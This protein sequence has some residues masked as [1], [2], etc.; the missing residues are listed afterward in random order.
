M[1]RR[2]KK[3]ALHPSVTKGKRGK[4]ALE[5]RLLGVEEKMAAP[6]AGT[7]ESV[8]TISDDEGDVQK[9]QTSLD[10]G[11][12]LLDRPLVMQDGRLEEQVL[13]RRLGRA[14]CRQRMPVR[15]RAS[16][17]HRPEERVRP[18]AACPTLRE[19]FGPSFGIQEVYPVVQGE[20][21]T[22]RGAGFVE[23]EQDI[24]EEVLDYEDGDEAEEGEIVQQRSVQKGVK[25]G[26]LQETTPRAVRSD[27]QV[28][29]D[30]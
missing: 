14:A 15:V 10:M 1:S 8:I 18:G 23:L 28:G 21:S 9:E 30:L 4:R 19:A 2:A 20:P 11:I 17:G 12:G 6:T 16:S 27:C 13:A 24:E 7:R 3:Q 26:A 5:E 22:S 25:L 29:G